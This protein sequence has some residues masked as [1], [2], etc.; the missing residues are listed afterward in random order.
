MLRQANGADRMDNY[1]YWPTTQAGNN[2]SVENWPMINRLG[3]DSQGK[4]AV[5]SGTEHLLSFMRHSASTPLG[6]RPEVQKR[7]NEKRAHYI[8]QQENPILEVAIAR[9]LITPTETRAPWEMIPSSASVFTQLT[10]TGRLLAKV[11]DTI[12]EEEHLSEDELY[13]RLAPQDW[14]AA[15]PIPLSGMSYS[16]AHRSY[17]KGLVNVV[18]FMGIQCVLVG[19]QLELFSLAH[20][21]AEENVPWTRSSSVNGISRVPDL[22]IMCHGPIVAPSTPYIDFSSM[23]HSERF[24]SL[25]IVGNPAEVWTMFCANMEDVAGRSALRCYSYTANDTA[26]TFPISIICQC[27]EHPTW[28]AEW[29][30]PVVRRDFLS[31]KRWG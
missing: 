5:P 7:P 28:V 14:P 29:T 2:P 22:G 26:L 1:F 12:F 18:A 20:G 25:G 3:M 21:I 8:I 11:A 27:Q 13:S 31:S 10:K 4:R 30:L 24:T 17:V 16:V 19:S 6:D 15:I 9:R 23:E